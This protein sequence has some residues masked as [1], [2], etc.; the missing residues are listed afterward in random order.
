MYFHTSTELRCFQTHYFLLSIAMFH[1]TQLPCEM[2]PSTLLAALSP[3]VRAN[4][5]WLIVLNKP[6]RVC[7]DF[8]MGA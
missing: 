5:S 1:N 6:N 7:A 2:W 3:V 8:H 4:C